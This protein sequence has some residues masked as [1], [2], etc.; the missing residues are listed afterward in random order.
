[1]S[2]ITEQL[3]R[4][5]SG[6]SIDDL[7]PEV[8]ARC[9][10]LLLDFLSATLGGRF[11]AETTQH[12]LETAT[13]LEWR[14]GSATVLGA[15]ADF[16]PP[17]AALIN[18]A[19]AHSLEFDDTHGAASLHPSATVVPAALA[20]AEM[21]DANGRDLVAAIVAGY[22]LGCRVSKALVP[23]AHYQRGF[24][25]TATVGV[26]AAAAAAARI[27]G[28]APD[29]VASALGLAGSQAAGSMQFMDNGAWNKRFHVGA[30]AQNGVIAATLARHGY[31]GA[32]AAIEG[33]NGFLNAYAPEPK[34]ELA[35]DGLGE[36][37]ETLS[38]ALK[39]YPACRLVHAAID[40][41]LELRAQNGLVADRA[42]AVEIGLSQMAIDITGHPQDIKRNP[43]NIVESQ[44]SAHLCA[45]IALSQGSLT[46]ADFENLWHDPRVLDLCK[47][48]SVYHDPDVQADYPERLSGR[49][50]ITVD[51]ATY[52]RKI[53]IPSGEPERFLDAEEIGEKFRGLVTGHIPGDQIVAISE[54][55]LRA[56]QLT[57]VRDLTLSTLSDPA[58]TTFPEVVVG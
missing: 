39:P 41:L 7:P 52:E 21:V 18:G 22:E 53:D 44:F 54:L 46:W 29:G 16:T 3:A 12:L 33:S 42:T 4:Y 8:V 28:L 43:R 58:A 37:Y 27:F 25:P 31:F 24:H 20:A 11:K 5:V 57:S 15:S 50:R 6:L 19:L 10:L 2:L 14:G 32:S 36:R 45:A 55:A 23:S 35:L 34:P 56:D 51:G 40:A 1:M 48:I 47:R 9:R 49:V 17:A 30:A 13:S 26:F 38:I